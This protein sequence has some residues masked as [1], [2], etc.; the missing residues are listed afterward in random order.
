MLG[1]LNQALYLVLYLIL[2]HFLSKINIHGS[3]PYFDKFNS[4]VRLLI[5][6]FL[7]DCIMYWC[8]YLFHAFNF[9]RKVHN[10]HHVE[11]SMDAMTAIRLHFFEYIAFSVAAIILFYTFAATTNERIIIIVISQVFSAY[12]H[13]DFRLPYK[14]EMILDKIF[15]T[16]GYHMHHHSN[17]TKEA[18]ENFGLIF[19]LWDRINKTYHRPEK[20]RIYQYGTRTDEEAS[21]SLVKN[22][23]LLLPYDKGAG[24]RGYKHKKV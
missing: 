9:T 15:V 7:Y 13:A 14:I 3:V 2:D 22:L 8:H 17:N 21:N 12:T 1:F 24:L 5:L 20:G 19:N 16:S 4:V 18:N 11:N 10:V 23:F 6:L